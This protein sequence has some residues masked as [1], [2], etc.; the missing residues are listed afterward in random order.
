MKLADPNN[1]DRLDEVTIVILDESGI[2]HWGHRLPGRLRL[3][4]ARAMAWGPWQFNTV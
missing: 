1:L 2:D 3:E 4:N